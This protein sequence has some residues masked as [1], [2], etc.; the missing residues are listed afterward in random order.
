VNVLSVQ[1]LRSPTTTARRVAQLLD[2]VSAGPSSRC[3]GRGKYIYEYNRNRTA[4]PTAIS[5]LARVFRF[6]C[7]GVTITVVGEGARGEHEIK[8]ENQ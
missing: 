2:D 4:P 5:E 7:N 3:Y 8:N 1:S 6:V